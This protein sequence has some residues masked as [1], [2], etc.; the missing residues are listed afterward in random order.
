MAYFNSEDGSPRIQGAE[1]VENRDRS[2]VRN[3]RFLITHDFCKPP[4]A[5]VFSGFINAGFAGGHKVPFNKAFAQWFAANYNYAGVFRGS[6]RNTGL[7]P[8]DRQPVGRSFGA[9]G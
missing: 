9:I 2:L 5:P 7:S 6:N 1:P 3:K 8:K 4:C